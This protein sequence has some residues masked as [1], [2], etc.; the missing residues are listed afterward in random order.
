M[1]VKIL[2]KNEIADFK[3]LIIVFKNVFENE[4]QIPSNDHLKK[5]LSNPDFKV[6]VV[7]LNGKVVGGLTVYVLQ[8]YY[9]TKP[10][11]YIYDVGIAPAFQGQGLGKALIADLC[12]YCKKNGFEEAYVEAEGDDIDAVNFYRKT[13]HNS[14]M[15]AVHFTYTF[16]K[17]K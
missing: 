13:K 9:S 1:E 14:E 10:T 15:N 4:Q 17:E 11:A 6:F 16:G 8:S 3:H 12:K 7:M 2:N 5:I